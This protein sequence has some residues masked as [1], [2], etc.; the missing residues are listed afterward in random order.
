[1]VWCVGDFRGIVNARLADLNDFLA[2]TSIV[3]PSTIRLRCC[4]MVVRVCLKTFL[5]R[6]RSHATFILPDKRFGS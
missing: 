4:S 2:A 1:V 5:K 3:L 6:K